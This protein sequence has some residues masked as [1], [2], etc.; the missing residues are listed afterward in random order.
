MNDSPLMVRAPVFAPLPV[1][2]GGFACIACDAPIHYDTWSAR[3]QGRS[4]SRH[5]NTFSVDDLVTLRVRDI[6]ARNAWLFLWWPDVHAPRMP[7]VMEAFGFKFSGKGFTWIKVLR[8]LDRRPALISTADI[9]TALHKGTGKTTRKNSETA[10]LGRRGRPKI[11]SHSVRE[12]IVAPIREHSRKPDEF[13]ER[14]ASF[15]AGPRLD[16]FGRQSC[17]GWQV[18]GDETRLFDPP[19]AV[20]TAP[21][22]EP[23]P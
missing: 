14:A 23:A 18:Y 9:E 11:L 8:S 3:G 2:E 7:E 21:V 20:L 4:P 19:A 22:L 17:P 12:I 1:V 16:L 15:C 10:W 6:V 5:Y 13:Y